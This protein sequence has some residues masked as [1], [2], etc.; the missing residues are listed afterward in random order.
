[1]AYQHILVPVDGSEISYTAIQE[2][3]T[4]AQAFQAKVTA[5]QVLTLDPYIAA[6]YITA[7]QTNE[8]IERAR[9]S[10]EQDLKQAQTK[11]A[12]FGIEVDTHL[13]EGQSISAEIV[14]ASEKIQADLIVI[15]SHG[16][17]GIKKFFLGSVA[18]SILADASVPVL[19]VRG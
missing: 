18:Q 10:I 17:T 16:R 6:E 9:Q 15:A 5:V 14:K 13:L 2:A 3:A 7:Q 1:M 12:E 8:L 11:F 19:I 4:L